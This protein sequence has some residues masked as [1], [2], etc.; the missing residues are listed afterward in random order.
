MN[1]FDEARFHNAL[2]IFE[3]SPDAQKSTRVYALVCR[4]ALRLQRD[5]TSARD[6]LIRLRRSSLWGLLKFWWLHRT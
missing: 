6:E 2:Q 4:G 5:L 1:S 3:N